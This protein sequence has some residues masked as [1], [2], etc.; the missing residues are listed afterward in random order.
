MREKTAL[1]AP[2]NLNEPVLWNTSHLKKREQPLSVFNVEQ[3]YTCTPGRCLAQIIPVMPVVT[4]DINN[5]L[6][7]RTGADAMHTGVTGAC[8]AMRI[9]ASTTS[10]AETPYVKA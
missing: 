2:R 9:S 1:H 5:Q 8:G 10:A 6:H 4:S 7:A 3:V